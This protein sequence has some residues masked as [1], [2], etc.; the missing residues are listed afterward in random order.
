MTGLLDVEMNMMHPVFKK[1]RGGEQKCG[2]NKKRH[3]RGYPF[4]VQICLCSKGGGK[5]GSRGS[6]WPGGGP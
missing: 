5:G 4:L 3:D 2:A 1:Q 6:G